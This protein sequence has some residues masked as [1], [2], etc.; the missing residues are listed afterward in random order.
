MEEWAEDAAVAA[1]AAHPADTEFIEKIKAAESHFAQM[2]ALVVGSAI[3]N[4]DSW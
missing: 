1:A 3:N 2:V 4:M